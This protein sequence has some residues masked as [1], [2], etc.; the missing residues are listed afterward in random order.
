[1]ESF[2]L[3]S[4][5]LENRLQKIIHEITES[6]I[7]IVERLLIEEESISGPI[8]ELLHGVHLNLPTLL[9]RRYYLKFISKC[10]QLI[11]K[12]L[13]RPMPQLYLQQAYSG[14]HTTFLQFNPG[15]S[16]AQLFLPHWEQILQLVQ[17][18]EVTFDQFHH[19]VLESN[20]DSV[21]QWQDKMKEWN[22]PDLSR[23]DITKAIQNILRAPTS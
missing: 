13:N 23:S 22:L 7:L 10:D 17:M 8:S 20:L 14:L 18:D 2:Q 16:N 15:F 9:F 12:L 19:I 3:V 1:V 5:N 11:C 4:D 21:A 6:H